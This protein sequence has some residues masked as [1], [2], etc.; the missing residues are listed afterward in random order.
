MSFLT[1]IQ[2]GLGQFMVGYH[3]SL[4]VDTQFVMEFAKRDV[5]KSI[6]WASG[7]MVDDVEKMLTAWRQNENNAGPGL[8]SMLPVVFL[9]LAKDY[10]PVLP[11][12]SVAVPETPFVFPGDPLERVY[13]VSTVCNEYKVQVVFVAPEMATAHSLLAQWHMW[14]TQGPT[15]RRFYSEYTFAGFKSKWPCVLEAIDPPGVVNALDQGNVTVLVSDMTIRATVPRFR[16]PGEGQANDGKTAPAGF[17]VVIDI[18]AQATLGGALGTAN[19][20]H[21]STTV[22]KA[23]VITQVRS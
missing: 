17:P 2:I 22:N 9:A 14:L 12:F 3:A 18:E 16:A 20:T 10:M 19:G 5:A 15:G 13:H 21:I 7:R 6:V 23:G 1:P 4:I 8:S 11:E